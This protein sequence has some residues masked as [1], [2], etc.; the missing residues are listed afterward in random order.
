M[1]RDRAWRIFSKKEHTKKKLIT[2]I[3]KVHYGWKDANGLEREYYTWFNH[4]NT[5]HHR[6]ALENQSLN[7]YKKRY[8]LI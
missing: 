5:Y 2:I 7:H 1:E 8:F 4:L 3:E 6:L